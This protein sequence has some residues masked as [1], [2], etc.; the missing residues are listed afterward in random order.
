MKQYIVIALAFILSLIPLAQETEKT[1]LK[2]RGI[3]EIG[4]Y[5]LELYGFKKEDY[6]QVCQDIKN[7]EKKNFRIRFRYA[8]DCNDFHCREVRKWI[9]EVEKMGIHI[10]RD[11]PINYIIARRRSRIDYNESIKELQYFQIILKDFNNLF[12]S[13][14]YN[15]A[16][17][18]FSLEFLKLYGERGLKNVDIEYLMKLQKAHNDTYER[19]NSVTTNRIDWYWDFI[20]KLND[21][22]IEWYL[23]NP[24]YL[25]N[26][27]FDHIIFQGGYG[28]YENI[29]EK[30]KK[31]IFEEKIALKD[32]NNILD[33][34]YDKNKGSFSNYGLRFS[35][36]QFLQD[37]ALKY[38]CQT[39]KYFNE[40]VATE[41]PLHV[42]RFLYNLN[43]TIDRESISIGKIVI[44]RLK[45]ENESVPI[46]IKGKKI[47]Y[48]AH[49]ECWEDGTEKFGTKAFIKRLEA[50]SGNKVTVIRLPQ[51]PTKKEYIDT[52]QAI[53]DD[54][55]QSKPGHLWIFDGHGSKKSFWLTNGQNWRTAA[56]SAK[57]PR[58]MYI[59]DFEEAFR[60]RH[61]KYGEKLHRIKDVF[62]YKFCFSQTV[63]R[64]HRLPKGYNPIFIM[65]TE[66]GQSSYSIKETKYGNNCFDEIF[67]KDKVFL[68]NFY[69]ELKSYQSNISIYI[70][71][72]Q[73]H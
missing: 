6:I 15:Q 64:S 31:L 25:K 33:I 52:K 10:K 46:T 37:P 7:L 9:E 4:Y 8:A 72:I 18:N 42:G 57:N 71:N 61:E 48:I 49:N 27:Y 17:D 26:L 51:T 23:L 50:I 73:I 28:I 36:S 12:N 38:M 2:K 60:K 34:I 13:T 45:R 30:I 41:I 19:R 5:Q 40:D 29:V 56:E 66:F 67:S 35:V 68:K 58:C 22:G 20:K 69:K 14:Q 32:L 16:I 53:I 47:T 63:C 11:Q 55:I 21:A 70:G 62:V 39:Y 1:F 65:G 44:E 3:D 24:E 43:M 59:T 54:I